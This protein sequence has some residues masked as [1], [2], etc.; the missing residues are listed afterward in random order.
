MAF[1]V[2]YLAEGVSR[3][4]AARAAAAGPALI[5]AL[6]SYP[7]MLTQAG[8]RIMQEKDITAAF[9]ASVARMRAA[10]AARLEDLTALHGG[11]EAEAALERLTLKRELI[12]EGVVKRS[13]FAAQLGRS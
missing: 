1:T 2:L 8:F 9:D 3:T 5:G 12:A 6:A 4:D 7:A 11:E 13:A 10:W